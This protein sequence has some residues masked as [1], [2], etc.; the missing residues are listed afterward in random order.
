MLIPFIFRPYHEHSG[1]FFWWGTERCYAEEYAAL[2]RY[3]VN[4][5]REKGLHNILYAYNTDKVYSAEEYLS[6]YPGDEYIDML[7][8]D[9]YGQGEEFNKNI[10]K[11]LEFTTQ[12]AEQKQK[13]HALSECGPISADLQRI[14]AQYKPR[15]YLH[16]GMPLPEVGKAFCTTYSRTDSPIACGCAYSL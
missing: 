12:I 14:L 11:A 6:G 9:W 10:D 7:S 8:I 16:G 3:T 4:F 13:L 2:W 5:L 15:T 1:S